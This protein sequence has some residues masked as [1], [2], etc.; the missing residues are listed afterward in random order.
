MTL[1]RR[2]APVMAVCLTVLLVIPAAVA[3][4]PQTYLVQSG[5]T[6]WSIAARF[7]ISVASLI[8][9]NQL[10]NPDALKLGQRLL[11]PASGAAQ[12]GR[13][14]SQAV[15]SSPVI[16]VVQ[17]GDTL[18]TIASRHRVSVDAIVEA[19]D[20]SNPDAL[21]LGQ[22]LVIPGRTAPQSVTRAPEATGSTQSVGW[23]AV[24][25]GDTLWTLAVRYRTTVHTLIA[26]ND[27]RNPDALTL[28]QRLK[29]PAP[30]KP[31]TVTP[32]AP[33]PAAPS[34]TSKPAVPAATM[35]VPAPA[36]PATPTPATLSPAPPLRSLPG[37]AVAPVRI[38]PRSAIPSR[39]ERWASAVQRV[40]LRVLGTRYRWGGVTPRGFDCSGFIYYVMTSVGV[41]LPRTTFAMFSTGRPVARTDLQVGDIVF[42]QTV[43]PGP[44]HAGI[45]VGNNLFM[46]SSSGIGRVSI[47]SL[48]YRYYKARYLGA[49]R[50]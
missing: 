39:G 12:T 29:V 14:T 26:L 38:L 10:T 21:K 8:S 9:A 4:A 27:L 28:G 49:R 48:D 30:A 43:S 50:F 3:A 20:L 32:T 40:G 41:G 6:L 46:H 33:K 2:A 25:P 7:G 34:T 45:Y 5:D 35:R 37:T 16:H 24:S 22:R 19:N 44:S 13:S 1:A 31:A 47:T 17:E 11:I 42:F 36:P 23:H 18:W 15:S